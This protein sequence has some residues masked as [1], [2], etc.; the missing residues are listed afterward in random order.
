MEDLY[1][2]LATT[3]ILI[4][5]EIGWPLLRYIEDNKEDDSDLDQ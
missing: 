4:M 1:M 5:I 3:A 2:I